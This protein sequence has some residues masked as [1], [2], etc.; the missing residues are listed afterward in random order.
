MRQLALALI[1]LSGCAA[2]QPAAPAA[3]IPS[4]TPAPSGQQVSDVV[5]SGAFVFFEDFEGG[6]GRWQLPASAEVGWRL[7]HAHTCTGE[8]SLLLGRDQAE[9]FTGSAQDS[10][11]TLAT[12]LDLAKSRRPAFK[13]DV[14]GLAMPDG[15]IALSLEVRP[16]GGAWQPLGDARVANHAFALTFVSDLSA[17]TGQTIDLRFHGV[18]KD[19]KEPTRGLY[20]DQLAVIEA[21]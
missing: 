18:V 5:P 14:L 13:Y 2:V 17:W 4:V 11:V 1:L 19:V 8:Y 20:L 6:T 15:A 21:R 12:G 10:Y 3:P 9:T 7:L 16:A